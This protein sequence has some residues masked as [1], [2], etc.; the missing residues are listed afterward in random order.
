[1]EPG[2]VTERIRTLLA[3]HNVPFREIQHAETHTSEESARARNE[4]VTI[5]GK[6]L[7]MKAGDAEFT[8]FVISAALKTDS[9]KIRNHLGIRKLRFATP[10]ELLDLT[11]LVPGSV[12]PFGRP[13]LPFNL[14][15][16]VSITRNEKIAFNAGALTTSIIMRCSDY[17]AIASPSIFEFS[18]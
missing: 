6:A 3:L 8:L 9:A 1:M 16:D 17:L 5:G 10:E 13:V 18:L 11:G 7:L 14:Y 2:S 12:P 4:S 15:V